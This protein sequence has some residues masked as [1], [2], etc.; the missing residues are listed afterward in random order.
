[1]KQSRIAPATA[2]QPT[3]AQESAGPGPAMLWALIHAAREV[4]DQLDAA[5]GVHGLS[6]AKY[7]VLQQLAAAGPLTLTDLAGRLSCV[8]SN[9]TQLVDRLEADGLVRREDDPADRR[10]V[11]AVLT[12]LGVQREAAGA[13]VVA[14]IQRDV[15]AK[16]PVTARAAFLRAL[17]ALK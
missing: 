5:L 7:G 2:T 3:G 16:V 4:E 14:E 1:M 6:P 9:V 10:T 17:S 13:V 11:R 12:A 8:R 15:A